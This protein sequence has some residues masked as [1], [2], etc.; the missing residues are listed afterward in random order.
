MRLTCQYDRVHLC[1]R[2]DVD[3][4]AVGNDVVKAVAFDLHAEP[5]L[6][7]GSALR[8]SATLLRTAVQGEVGDKSQG[9]RWAK[10]LLISF[11]SHNLALTSNVA[12]KTHWLIIKRRWAGVGCG[13]S[14][15]SWVGVGHAPCTAGSC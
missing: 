7:P 8:S 11:S 14:K 9:C 12:Y 1:R 10:P 3:E 6:L 15:L 2:R 4:G 13:G 5:V